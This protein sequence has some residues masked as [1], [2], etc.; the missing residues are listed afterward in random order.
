[1]IHFTPDGMILDANNTFLRV[2]G[3]TAAEVV[4]RHHSMFV[5][6]EYRHSQAYR[7]FWDRLRAGDFFSDEF[8]RITKNNKVIWISATYAPVFDEDGKVAQITKIATE[9]TRQHETLRTISKG[10]EALSSGDLTY[11]IDLSSQDRMKELADSFNAASE[12]MANLIRQVKSVSET[13][14]G[15]SKIVSGNAD[16]LSRRTETQAATLEQTAAAVDQL[17]HAAKTAANYASEVAREAEDTKKAAGDSSKVVNDVTAAMQR[18]EESSKSISQ[19]VSVIDDIAFQTN[20]LAL[21]AG[22]EAARAGEA[23]RGFAVVA[24]EVRQLAQR[25]AE[26]AKEIKSLINQSSEYVHDGANLVGKASG[27]LGGIFS[28]VD[29]IS[30]R[31]REV[32]SGLQ[33][34]TTSL[35]EINT[36]VSHMDTVTQKNA[37]MVN[38]AAGVTLELSKNSSFLS[39]AISIFTVAPTHMALR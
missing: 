36:A 15:M 2:L 22:V 28:S 9:I 5:Q 24:S 17:N 4:G 12:K 6:E 30:E 8:P 11:R 26:S 38:E 34:Q 13:I 31:I 39:D 14:D 29:L 35:A 37:A 20:L 1:M 32:V 27:E 10:L 3:Y 21:N 33:E 19:I 25:S 16:E 23:G 7:Q 18:I